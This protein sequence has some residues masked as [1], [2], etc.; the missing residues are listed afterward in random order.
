MLS[1]LLLQ[2]AMPGAST[3]SL[4]AEG[5]VETKAVLVVCAVLSL[6]SWIVIIAK[7]REFGRVEGAGKRF[8]E[9]VEGADGLAEAYHAVSRLPASAFQRVFRTAISFVNDVRPG[10]L[11]RGEPGAPP[12]MAAQQLDALKLILGKEVAAEREALLRYVPWLATIGA[13]GP[14]LGL[15]GTVL[16]VMNSF[17]G[18]ATSGSGNI[19]AVAPGIAEALIATAAGLVAAIPAVVAYNVFATRVKRLGGELSGF[20]TDLVGTLAREGLL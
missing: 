1:S 7:L 3:W 12:A 17:L 14:L 18:V 8:F 2:G 5:S 16:G 10:G 6:L 4:V 13:T 20:A 19:A 9:V 15:L 11:R